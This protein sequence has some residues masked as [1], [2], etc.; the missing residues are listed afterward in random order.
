ME[1]RER[2]SRHSKLLLIVLMLAAAFALAAPTKAL[3]IDED[4]LDSDDV[5]YVTRYGKVFHLDKD[6]NG[7]SNASSVRETTY[8]K[9]GNRRLCELCAE[10]HDG[11]SHGSHG[12]A[13]WHAS[14]DRW[15]YGYA[16]GG[17]AWQCWEK[18]GG[19][20]YYFD[21]DGWMQTGW[22]RV[23]GSWYYL[24][25]SG[26]MQTGW[27]SSGGDWYHLGSSGVMTTGW[28][29]VGGS[30][31]C[32]AGDGS[33]YADTWIGNYYLGSSGAMLTSCKT[34]DGYY[35]DASGKWVA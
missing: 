35:V 2:I 27:L 17:Y 6:C 10:R 22:Q 7:L 26:K 30:W 21:Y 11:D 18:I 13:G 4:D 23:S 24:S 20:W 3:A 9:V 31:Y 5:V 33:M 12:N 1:A 25:S 14:G 16:N 19:S 34:P 29:K 15:W 8:G 32:F 28:K